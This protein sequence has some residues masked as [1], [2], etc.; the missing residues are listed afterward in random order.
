MQFV[1]DNGVICSTLEQAVSTMR[2][3]R[4]LK[5]SRIQH[6]KDVLLPDYHKSYMEARK[7]MSLHK[8]GMEKEQRYNA[9]AVLWT[10]LSETYSR[11]SEA[12]TAYRKLRIEFDALDREI[13]KYEKLVEPSEVRR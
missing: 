3:Q 12:I 6:Y 13:R 11:L 10:N 4:K 1:M 5:G 2:E 8:R 9:M 7:R